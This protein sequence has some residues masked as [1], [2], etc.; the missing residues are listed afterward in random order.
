MYPVGIWAISSVEQC[1]DK[2]IVFCV[3]L[4]QANEMRSFVF[5][6]LQTFYGKCVV[7]D[8]LNHILCEDYLLVTRVSKNK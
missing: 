2:Q 4:L 6:F 3:I 8:A 1:F 7:I 5:S